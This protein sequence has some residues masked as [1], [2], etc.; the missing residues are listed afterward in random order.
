[1]LLIWNIN[2]I[3]LNRLKYDDKTAQALL[4]TLN[5]KQSKIATFYLQI[6]YKNL[7]EQNTLFICFSYPYQAGVFFVLFF[8]KVITAYYTVA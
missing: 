6:W 5:D 3:H 4:P 2:Y 8:C 1:M 7:K